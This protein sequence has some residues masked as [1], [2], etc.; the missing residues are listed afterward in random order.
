MAAI[1]KSDNIAE[2]GM[3][4]FERAGLGKA[5]FRC[6]GFQVK[7]FQA[8]PDAPVQPGASCAYCHTGIMQCFEITSRD[9]KKFEVGCDCVDKTGD[10]GLIR[11]YKQHPMVRAANR[12]KSQA[13]DERVKA[14]WASLIADETSNA[15][16]SSIFVDAYKGGQETWLAFAIR[17]W[18]YCGAAGRGRY[19]RTAKK[20]IA[21]KVAAK[22]A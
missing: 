18:G 3:H 13:R 19:L 14:E 11:S 8:H 1:V 22:A 7:K 15:L 10:R 5:P 12:A 17:A 16:L 2:I 6:T 4:T 20:I 9:G 21:E